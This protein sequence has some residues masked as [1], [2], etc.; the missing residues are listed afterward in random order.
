MATRYALFTNQIICFRGAKLKTTSLA[1]NVRK[2]FGKGR[3]VP[4]DDSEGYEPHFPMD[5]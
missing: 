1:Y 3:C 4:M 2:E 5:P